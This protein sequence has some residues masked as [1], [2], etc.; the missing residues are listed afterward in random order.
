MTVLLDTHALLWWQAGGARL[1][2]AA[3]RAIRDADAVL[4]SPLSCWEMATLQ[5]QGKIELDRD[6]MRWAHALFLAPRVEVADLSVTAATWAGTLD[7]EGFPGDPIDRMLYAT[8]MDLRVPLISKDER[9][10]EFAR[11]DRRVHVIW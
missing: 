4:V 1:S 5:R 6:A 8:A 2:P 10:T 11:V 9:L 7:S 3:M